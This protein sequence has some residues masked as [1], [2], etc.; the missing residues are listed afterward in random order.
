MRDLNSRTVSFALDSN[1]SSSPTSVVTAHVHPAPSAGHLPIPESG[2]NSRDALAL[3]AV[4]PAAPSAP[5]AP[6]E[7]AIQAPPSPKIPTLPQTP[8]SAADPGPKVVSPPEPVPEPPKSTQIEVAHPPS[9]PPA[10]PKTTHIRVTSKERGINFRKEPEENSESDIQNIAAGA[11]VGSGDGAI[12]VNRETTPPPPHP[13]EHHE[14]DPLRSRITKKNKEPESPPEA[15]INSD[16]TDG[17]SFYTRTPEKPP[18]QDSTPPLNK[19]P[20]AVSQPE[21]ISGPPS[22]QVNTKIWSF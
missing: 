18:V 16:V 17:P 15:Q 19:N 2:D 8:Q 11:Q 12:T 4:A 13:T 21:E 1:P 14:A 20:D 7:P 10:S 3:P 22:T 5:P 6:P 9:T